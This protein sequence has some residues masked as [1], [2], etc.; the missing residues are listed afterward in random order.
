MNYILGGKSLCAE[1]EEH[2]LRSERRREHYSVSLSPM[3]CRS[4]R[5]MMVKRY[6]RISAL[7]ARSPTKDALYVRWLTEVGSE[8]PLLL[9]RLFQQPFAHIIS[10]IIPFRA[11]VPFYLDGVLG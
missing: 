5:A 6:P 9:R 1:I 11:A 8:A 2:H 10:A 4:D 3:T 7:F